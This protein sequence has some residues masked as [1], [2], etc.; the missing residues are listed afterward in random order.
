MTE[1]QHQLA[2]QLRAR[3]VLREDKSD[4]LG[5]VR[6]EEL[7]RQNRRSR[8]YFPSIFLVIDR[9]SYILVLV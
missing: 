4:K 8:V 9:T 3:R 5:S 2:D 7:K 6:Y 1:H